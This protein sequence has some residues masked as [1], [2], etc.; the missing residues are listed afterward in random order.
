MNGVTD[1][2]VYCEYFSHYLSLGTAKSPF[3]GEVGAIKVAHLNT[4][5]PFFYQAVI[6]SDSQAAILAITNCS[7]APSSMSVMQCRSLMG[8]MCEKYKM[9]ALQWILSHCGIP[10]NEN[11]DVLTKKD[12]LV[13]QAPYNPV[14]F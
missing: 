2:Q 1:A 12:C 6:F 9:I 8:N 14:S 13:N 11:E 5:P 10:S 7:L 3:D 4:Y